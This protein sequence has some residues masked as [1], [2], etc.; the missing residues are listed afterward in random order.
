MTILYASNPFAFPFIQLPLQRGSAALVVGTI[1]VAEAFSSSHGSNFATVASTD[2]S[3]QHADPCNGGHARN[4]PHRAGSLAPRL[5]YCVL[6]LEAQS[7]PG[8]EAGASL[9]LR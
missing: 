9:I 2:R 8:P 4:A 6:G 3:R 7:W 1:N 5:R